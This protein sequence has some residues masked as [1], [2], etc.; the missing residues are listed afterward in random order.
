MALPWLVR[1]LAQAALGAL[2][3]RALE[4]AS[5]PEADKPARRPTLEEPDLDA[6]APFACFVYGDDPIPEELAYEQLDGLDGPK[7][8]N[9]ILEVRNR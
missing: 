3:A 6:F 4:Q 2:G 1:F 5:E 7:E 9:L 8:P